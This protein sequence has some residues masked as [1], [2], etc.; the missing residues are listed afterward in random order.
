MNEFYIGVAT[1]VVVL[2]W[3][4]WRRRT[5]RETEPTVA[6][7]HGPWMIYQE[8]HCGHYWP[9]THDDRGEPC[10]RCGCQVEPDPKIAR[11]VHDVSTLNG[12]KSWN[13]ARLVTW[14]GC[15]EQN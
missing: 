14:L 3:L 1:V 7:E 5:A 2:G 10:A 9:A 15:E 12:R 8:C 6:Q 11:Q 4:Q 13:N